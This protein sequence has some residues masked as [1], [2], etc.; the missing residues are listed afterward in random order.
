MRNLKLFFVIPCILA[1]GFISCNP[2]AKHT[3]NSVKPEVYP[4]TAFVQET[5]DAYMVSP[6]NEDNQVRSIAVDQAA[7]VW[8]A[9]ASGIFRKT[10]DSRKWEPI[11]SGEDRGPAYSIVVNPD[12]AVLIGTWNGIYRF[13]NT[14]LQKEEGANPPISIVCNDDEGNYAM[15]PNGI[16]HSK[17]NKWVEEEYALARSVRDAAVDGKGNLWVGTDA[18]LYICQNGKTTLFQNTEELISCYVKAISFS[19]KGD[20]WAGV[21]GGVSVRR[22][23]RLIKNLTPEEGISSANVNCISQS[24]DGLMWVGTDVGVVRFDKDYSHSLRFSR[25]WLTNNKVNDVAFDREGNAWVATDHG[26]S[27]IKRNLMTLADKEKNFYSQLM[28]KYIR[29]PWTCGSLRLQVPGDTSSWV[30]SDDDNDGEYT[31]GYLAMESFRYAATKD[32]DAKIKAR[33]AFEFLKYLQTVTGTEGFFARSIVP[34]DWTY[35]HDLNRTYTPK[36]LAEELV[37]DPRYKPVEIRWRKSADGKW[38]WKGDTSTDEMD[39]HMMGYFYFY[40]LAADSTEKI[41]VRDHVKKIIDHLIE[42]GYNLLDLDGTPTHWAIWSPEQL[43]HDPDWA[44]ERSI[45]SFELLTYLKFVGH[46]TGDEKYEKEYR[47]L[48]DKEGYLDNVSHLNQK[49]PAWQIYFDRTLEGYLFPIILKYEKDPKLKEFYQ[50]L[51]D[52]WMKNQPFGENLINNLSYAYATGKTVNVP[53]TIGFLRDAPLD[54]VDWP[55]NHTLREDVQIVRSPIL[56]EI[57]ISELP[58]A[59]MRATVRWDKNPWSAVQGNLTQVREPVFWLWPYWEARYLGI[60]QK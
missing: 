24:P 18:G 44:S 51:M 33:K 41:L 1:L 28:K 43:N 52:E 34:P 8:I 32:P 40:E 10:A 5:H 20:L 35:V 21:L 14:Q 45:N 4:D 27:N 60:I 11:I 13:F 58:P 38:L 6:D 37:K 54:L 53:Q 48:I 50:K 9:T 3:R 22:D 36:Q 30:N 2:Q 31:G 47:R 57:Q 15:G 46:L 25:R 29:A 26:V 19:P 55:I 23:E 59:S 49:N 56:E 16:W 39:G 42:T 7:N 17:G 12:G